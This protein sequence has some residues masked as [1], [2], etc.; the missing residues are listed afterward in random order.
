MT[1][2]AQRSQLI[3]ALFAQAQAELPHATAG[4]LFKLVQ[5]RLWTQHGERATGTDIARALVA[6]AGFV[7]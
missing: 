3:D 7:E 6:E 2:P 4:T 5:H 1:T